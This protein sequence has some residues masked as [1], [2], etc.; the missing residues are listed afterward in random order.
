MSPVQPNSIRKLDTNCSK[1]LLVPL[2]RPELDAIEAKITHAAKK[3][4]SAEANTK[5]IQRDLE[6]NQAELVKHNKDLSDVEKVLEKH[7]GE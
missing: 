1:F 2:Q 5:T 4:R 6:S 7:N 3:L